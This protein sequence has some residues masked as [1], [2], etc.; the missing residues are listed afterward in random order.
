[1]EKKKKENVQNTH[2]TLKD[3]LEDPNWQKGREIIERDT[4]NRLKNHLYDD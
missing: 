3:C 1:M 2:I 4:R